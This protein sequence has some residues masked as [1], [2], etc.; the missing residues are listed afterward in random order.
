MGEEVPEVEK[1]G[2]SSNRTHQV[3][4]TNISVFDRERILADFV[5]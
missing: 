1:D 5:Y 4:E 2:D 3:N